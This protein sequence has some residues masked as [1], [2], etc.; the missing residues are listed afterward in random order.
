MALTPS[1]LHP[2]PG[3][4]DWADIEA[5]TA[6]AVL[7]LRS[8]LADISVIAQ[9]YG[10]EFGCMTRPVQLELRTRHACAS[11]TL[12]RDQ[13]H[14]HLHERER[15]RARADAT[16]LWLVQRDIA[17]MDTARLP[18]TVTHPPPVAPPPPQR[19][20]PTTGRMRIFEES[21]A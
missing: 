11:L 10:D 15:T 8:A 3:P 7:H 1:S 21:G 19:R 6:R 5:R 9:R 16:P 2:T 14:G 18:P 20:G 17:E 13:A 12:L 4:V